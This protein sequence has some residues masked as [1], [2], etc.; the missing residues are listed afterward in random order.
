M[1]GSLKE[2]EKFKDPGALGVEEA[3]WNQEEW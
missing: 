1:P 2:E 3:S